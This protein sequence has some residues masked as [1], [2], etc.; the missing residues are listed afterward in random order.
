MINN[1]SAKIR[2]KQGFIA[3]PDVF[4]RIRFIIVIYL[5]GVAMNGGSWNEGGGHSIAGCVK[6]TRIQKRG[7]RGICPDPEAKQILLILLSRLCG[8]HIGK[9]HPN[10]PCRASD[11]NG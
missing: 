5:Y 11:L 8:K 1:Y 9:T 6:T 2:K 7:R 10:N 4:I 3:I